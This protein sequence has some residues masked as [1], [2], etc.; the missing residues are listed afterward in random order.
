MNKIRISIII[1]VYNVEK[2]LPK[3][4]DSAINQ[5]L[6]EIEII[7]INDCSTDNSLE[8]LNNYAQKDCRI[9]IINLEKNYGQG[10]ARNIGLEKVCG[11]Y[12]G[13]IDA[14]DWI[15]YD[16]CEKLYNTAIKYNA[17]IVS[18]NMLKH[19]KFFK[20]Y[21]IL[22]KKHYIKSAL[23][24]KINLCKDKKN[25]FFYVINK[26]YRTSIIK[27]NEIKFAQGHIYEDVKFAIESIFYANSIVTVPNTTYHYVERENSSV[28]YTD[29]EG[30]KQQ[31]LV[32]AYSYLQ[33]F[34][35]KH[36]IILPERLNYYTS[37]WYN[38][39][40]KTYLGNY[41]Y[42]QFLLGL[43]PIK[44][45]SI[46]FTFPVDMVYLW[47]DGED[48]IWSHKKNEFLKELNNNF[49]E[50]ATAKGRFVNNDELKFS[51]RSLEKYASW[52]NKIYIVTDNQIPKWLDTNNP[53]IKVVFHKDFIPNENLP[54][55]NS[56]AIEC[57]LPFIPKLSEHF[58]YGNDDIFFG[59]YINKFFFF[60]FDKKP[61]IRLKHQVSPKYILTSMYTRSI[62]N[63]QK[64]IKEEFGKEIPYAPH[65]NI[66]AY[67]KSLFIECINHYLRYFL[68]T[69][70]HKFR[71]EGDIQRVIVAYYGLVKKYG[72][73]K[74]YSRIDRFLSI[75]ERLKRRLKKDYCTDSIVMNMKSKNPYGKLRKYK[76][77]LFC[78][79]DGEGI[80][81][82]DRRRTK[83]FL[84]ETF[85]EKSE[86]E[87][88]D[89]ND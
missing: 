41:K 81:D 80:T 50:Q 21:N 72:I 6:K 35:Q 2:Y 59:R 55:F 79:N 89:Y 25:N 7:C 63:M 12:T 13:F 39:F 31:D 43:I 66:D 83:I 77:A 52:I 9:K 45:S 27:D 14:D 60:T 61:I 82:F 87:L 22:H 42:K 37:I 68:K 65:H 18:A 23:K 19:K 74:F 20:R 29:K 30:K 16:F 51:L 36:K 24:D 76:P 69:M 70:S 40:I 17:D 73:L 47:V 53:K 44:S 5:T 75:F 58:I 3:C 32:F 4:L 84:E 11:D 34:A 56:E 48:E 1:P 78:T 54:L 88:P 38:P 15:D 86:F 26:I 67:T 57:Y 46:D 62:L 71:T 10:Y 8:I 64:I 28:K 85:P 49:N 33:D